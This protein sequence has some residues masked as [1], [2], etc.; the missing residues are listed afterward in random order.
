MQ[1]DVGVG[2]VVKDG[3]LVA[4]ESC[5][6]RVRSGHF[7]AACAR[8]FLSPITSEEEE[9]EEGRMGGRQNPPPLSP[10]LQRR[11]GGSGRGWCSA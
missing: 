9:E 10:S 7:C 6:A 1:K 8:I 11:E 5:G 4:D 2:G 3:Y